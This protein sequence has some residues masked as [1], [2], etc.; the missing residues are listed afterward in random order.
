[1]RLKVDEMGA[2]GGGEAVM[3]GGARE[4]ELIKRKN[5]KDF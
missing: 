5:L 2:G 4:K 3:K 1:M